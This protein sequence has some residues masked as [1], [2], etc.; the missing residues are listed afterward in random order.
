MNHDSETAKALR[1]LTAGLKALSL[2]LESYSGDLDNDRIEDFVAHLNRFLE[3][4]GKTSD[5]EK[6]QILEMHLKGSAKAWYLSLSPSA[7]FDACIASLVRRFSMTD[8][9]IHARKLAVFKSSQRSS[10][11]FM[12]FVNRVVSNSRGCNISQE[13][14]INII[15]LGANS[16]IRPHLLNEYQRIETL[17]DLL[18]LPLTR[19]EGRAIEP[20]QKKFVGLTD[21]APAPESS[22]DPDPE[23]TNEP[24]NIL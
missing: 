3:V 15:I 11:N 10:E 23:L 1:S 18:A 12:S 22:D 14:L 8:T 7:T 21:L 9:Q 17:D 4:T 20:V 5:P 6:K 2:K 24:C 16:S 19:D 13:D